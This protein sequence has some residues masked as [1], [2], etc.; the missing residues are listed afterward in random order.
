MCSDT[1]KISVLKTYRTPLHTA[2]LWTNSKKEST[3]RM[4]VVHNNALRILLIRRRWCNKKAGSFYLSSHAEEHLTA[5]L[6]YQSS[7]LAV[8]AQHRSGFVKSILW[9]DYSVAHRLEVNQQSRLKDK[10]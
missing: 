9:P 8:G 2:Q 5:T 3:Q 7:V 6:S 10:I 1:V 4:Q